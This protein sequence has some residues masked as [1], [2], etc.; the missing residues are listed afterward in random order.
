[1]NIVTTKCRPP[2]W[3]L[4]YYVNL[5]L[6]HYYSSGWACTRI[7]HHQHTIPLHNTNTPQ[8]SLHNNATS[9]RKQLKMDVLT[10][11]TCWAVNWHNK[12]S[13][14]KLVY[15][16]SNIKMMHGPISIRLLRPVDI[17]NRMPPFELNKS[18]FKFGLIF[19]SDFKAVLRTAHKTKRYS[20]QN[21]S[22]Y[23]NGNGSCTNCSLQ[24]YLKKSEQINNHY[25]VLNLL[26]SVNEPTTLHCLRTIHLLTLNPSYQIRYW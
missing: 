14:I 8:V 26:N 9:S 3:H 7:P 10:S 4:L 21:A 17:S 12:A 25:S 15:L 20:K 16:Y 18:S 22:N 23:T 2:W 1:M 11:E 24:T 19:N 5:L 13:L 6:N